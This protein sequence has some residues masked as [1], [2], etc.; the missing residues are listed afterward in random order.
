M[1]EEVGIIPEELKKR[2]LAQKNLEILRTWLKLASRSR[3]IEEFE[4]GI[5]DSA[6]ETGDRTEN[7][8]PG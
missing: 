8:K 6:D 4:A 5:S 1:L 3:S 7:N 2:I